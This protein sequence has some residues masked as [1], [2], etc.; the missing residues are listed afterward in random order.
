MSVLSPNF[1]I[2]SISIGIVEDA[3]CINIGN[4]FPMDFQSHKKQNQ[5]FGTIA[6]HGNHLD[7]MKSLLHDAAVLDFITDGKET[8]VP[9]WVRVLIEQRLN[10][11]KT[12]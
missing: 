9:D 6:G 1:V 8:V 5:G 12:P 4:N 10:Q 2:G 3:S 11:E 7:G